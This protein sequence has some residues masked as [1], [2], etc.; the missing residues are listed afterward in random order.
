MRAREAEQVQA[1]LA[2]HQGNVSAAA[3][4]LGLARSTLVS[5]MRRLGLMGPLAR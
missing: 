5:R 2:A 4:Q 1:A 3:R